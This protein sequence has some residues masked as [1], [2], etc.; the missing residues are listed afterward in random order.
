MATRLGALLAA[1]A[2]VGCPGSDD[3]ESRT[4]SQK[5]LAGEWDFTV[6]QL[7]ASVAAGTVAGWIRGTLRVDE[8]GQVT[9]LSSLN[10]LGVTAV[11]AVATT[12]TIDADGNV[13][14]T[15]SVYT[16]YHAK[17]NAARDLLV[18][19]AT[20]TPTGAPTLRI[21]QKRVP[22]VTFSTADLAGTWR[23]NDLGGGSLVR[24]EYGTA[25]IA[26]NGA[27][28]VVQGFASD[29]GTVAPAPGAETLAVSADGVVTAA[30]D[31][32]WR[33]FLAAD[34]S[35]IVATHT[36]APHEYSLNVIVRGASSLSQKDFAGA[37]AFHSL[38]NGATA[39]WGHGSVT[40][41]DVGAVSFTEAVDAGGPTSL[42]AP[43]TVAVQGDG[44]VTQVAP[45]GSDFHGVLSADGK[46]TVGVSS[47]DAGT[48]TYACSLI[49]STR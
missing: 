26:S 42:P 36:A 48:A 34:K 22:G 39:A 17:L 44:T 23:Y 19:T 45:P 35:L 29:T 7:G 18:A 21:S 8:G 14:A 30:G 13:T 49:V 10:S 9:I 11:P 4:F 15:S 6:L 3:E 41:S 33:G 2:L 24:Y 20:A 1:V 27:V 40:A 38:S 47:R 5:D 25:T 37:W 46:L 43:F 31:A 32:S 16:Q 28:S 12:W